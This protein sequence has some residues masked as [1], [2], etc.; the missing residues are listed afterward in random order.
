M[1]SCTELD[2]VIEPIAA[3]DLEA[4]AVMRAHLATCPRCASALALARHIDRVLAMQSAPD[5]SSGFTQALMARM[6][7]ERWRSEQY[8]DLAFNAAVA[9][10]IAAGVGGLWLVLTISGLATVSADLTRVV[11]TAAGAALASL[12]PA[13]PVYAAAAAVFVSGMALW[14]WAEHGLEI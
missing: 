11:V 5:P 7:R 3:G 2:E 13:L 9:L 4:D 6:R 12:V 10:A 14:W 8:L 1:M